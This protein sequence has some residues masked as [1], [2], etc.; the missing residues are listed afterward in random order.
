[1]VEV[2]KSGRSKDRAITLTC[3]RC[4][5]RLRF[6]ISEA[7]LVHDSR[8]GDAYVINCPECKKDNWYAASLV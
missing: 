5:A 7:R 1:M 6:K 8:D 4:N 2:L 3:D